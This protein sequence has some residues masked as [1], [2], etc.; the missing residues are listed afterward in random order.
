MTKSISIA[1][2]VGGLLLLAACNGQTVASAPSPNA[3]TNQTG[4]MAY[5]APSPLGNVSTTP[6][7]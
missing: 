1:A 2:A 5:P 6:V 3:P 4:S 7:R